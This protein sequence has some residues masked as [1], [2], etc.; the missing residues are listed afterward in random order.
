MSFKQRTTKPEK[1]NKYYIRKVNGGWSPCIQGSPVDSE[2]DVLS[3]CVGYAIGRFNEIGEWG[4][5]KYL[6]SVNAENFI[7]YKGSSLEVG[8]A[9][10]LG[11]CM[12]WQKGATLDGADG[13]GHVAIVERVI[14]DTEVFTSESAYGG[15][16]FYNSTRRKGSD[17]KWGMGTGYKFLGFIYNP[18]ECCQNP[19]GSSTNVAKTVDEVAAEVI[20]GKWGCGDERK[21][22]LTAAG[23]DYAVVQAA[24]NAKLSGQ[25]ITTAAKRTVGEI[26]Q[27]VI[28][29][30]WGNWQERVDRLSA[31]GYSAGEISEIQ[32][33]VNEVLK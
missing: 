28:L 24:V 21:S 23:Y 11:A 4:S 9:P 30:K 3:N 26:V 5:C 12:V 31:V 6:A 20:A 2:C 25:K 8:Q 17:G 14:S 27:K 32:K 7:Q 10:K 1:G 18:A 29:G 16:A 33:R 22:R 15:K 13:A 19:S